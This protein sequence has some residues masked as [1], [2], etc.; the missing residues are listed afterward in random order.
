M[1]GTTIPMTPTHNSEATQ[2]NILDAAEEA[3]AT[4]GYAGARVDA[5]AAAA[6][7]NKRMLYHYFGDKA[8]LYAAAVNRVARRV[9]ARIE[10]GLVEAEVHDPVTALAHLIEVF[11]DAAHDE[12]HYVKL[13]AREGADEWESQSPLG[14]EERCLALQGAME[15][16]FRRVLPLL[17]RGVEQG[18]LRDDLDLNMVVV[19]GILLCRAYLLALPRLDALDRRP[20]ATSEGLAWAKR[21]IVTLL[22]EGLRARTPLAKGTPLLPCGGEGNVPRI[23][24]DAGEASEE[25]SG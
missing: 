10:R 14:Q 4:H 1:G 3:F 15:A 8:G 25:I 7:V 20:L 5:I 22:L 18:V 19:L 13:M 17:R 21:H 6:N 23:S 2:A 9:L 16:L 11:F 24:G 12:P